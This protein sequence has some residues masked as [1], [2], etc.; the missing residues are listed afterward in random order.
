MRATRLACSVLLLIALPAHAALIVTD[1][2]DAWLASLPGSIALSIDE[3]LGEEPVGGGV[4]QSLTLEGSGIVVSVTDGISNAATDLEIVSIHFDTLSDDGTSISSDPG[5][6]L[7]LAIDDHPTDPTQLTFQLPSL[8]NAVSFY[9]DAVN[10]DADLVFFSAGNSLTQ[11]S[12]ASTLL[13]DPSNGAGFLGYVDTDNAFDS[14]TLTH[15]SVFGGNDT[16]ESFRIGRITAINAP[17][18]APAGFALLAVAVG[19]LA[20][21][22]LRARAT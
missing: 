21:R 6:S 20:W 8:V 5:Q 22:A 13:V 9:Y 2:R 3:G 11:T 19:A 10:D 4:T 12:L 1:H 7:N 17:V 15:S 14:F 16:Q 18:P